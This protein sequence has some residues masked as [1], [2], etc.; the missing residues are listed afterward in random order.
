MEEGGLCQRQHAPVGPGHWTLRLDA[1]AR[2]D[3]ADRHN[4]SMSWG[5]RVGLIFGTG[6][7]VAIVAVAGQF[8]H[9]GALAGGLCLGAWLSAGYSISLRGDSIVLHRYGTKKVVP[10]NQVTEVQLYRYQNSTS[11]RFFDRTGKRIAW[12]GVRALARHPEAATHL[13][14]WLDRPEVAWGPGTWAFVAPGPDVGSLSASA[15]GDVTSP[16]SHQLK[17]PLGRIVRARPQSKWARGA[18]WVSLISLVVVALTMLVIVPVTWSDYALSQRIQ[19]GPETLAKVRS[20]WVTSST[21]RYGT[22]HT[23]HLDVSFYDPLTGRT[24]STQVEAPGEF[25]M[26]PAGGVVQVRYDP[27]NPANAE[28]PGY[29]NHT[30][31]LSIVLTG[32]A[33]LLWVITGLLILRWVRVGRITRRSEANAARERPFGDFLSRGDP[34]PV[35]PPPTPQERMQLRLRRRWR[36]VVLGGFATFVGLVVW[37]SNTQPHGSLDIAAGTF[38]WVLIAAM[39]TGGVGWLVASRR[40]RRSKAA[41]FSA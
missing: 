40:L 36:I 28:L 12:V 10:L 7:F 8:A 25:S 6:V 35:A 1:P 30:L 41:R 16:D 13:R 3:G 33:L 11:L 15:T 21:D 5:L 22:H 38:A 32:V 2:C 26:V 19:H 17:S 9:F 24:I 29:P 39:I 14:H 37:A 4:L 34:I 27:S 18:L 31:W 23:T 20:E